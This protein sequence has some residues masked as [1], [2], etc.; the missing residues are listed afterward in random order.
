MV[1]GGFPWGDLGL[2]T[3]LEA[4]L[5]KDARGNC[6]VGDAVLHDAE[7]CIVYNAGGSGLTIGVAGVQDLVVVATP[8][9]ILV[10]P[11]NRAQDVR[12]LVT[13]L[14]KRNAPQV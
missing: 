8:D 12:H 4:V 10:V 6:L 13:E 14:R 1:E 11:K 3:S 2:W 9:A 5:E 7:G